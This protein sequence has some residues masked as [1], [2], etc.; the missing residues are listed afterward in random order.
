MKEK[1]KILFF[2]CVLLTV[3]ITVVFFMQTKENRQSLLNQNHKEALLPHQSVLN[4]TKENEKYIL[5]E[6]NLIEHYVND[7]LD[8]IYKVSPQIISYVKGKNNSDKLYNMIAKKCKDAEIVYQSSTDEEVFNITQSEAYDFIQRNY[9][10]GKHLLYKVDCVK[11]YNDFNCGKQHYD[12]SY[13]EQ[14]LINNYNL[15]TEYPINDSIKDV[16]NASVEKEFFKQTGL[17][18]EHI[19]SVFYEDD[20]LYVITNFDMLELELDEN[21]NLDKI[22]KVE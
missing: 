4:V 14:T 12:P 11:V 21:G 9:R 18:Q 17:I 1:L 2:G 5:Y 10:I 22:I 20:K 19:V 6:D 15:Y 16:V 3:I 13:F 8:S 7:D